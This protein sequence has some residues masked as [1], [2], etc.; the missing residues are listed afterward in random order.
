MPLI[1]FPAVPNVPG[2]PALAR[3]AVPSLGGLVNMAIAA[4]V[5]AVLGAAVWGVFDQS[6]KPALLPDSFLDID[7]KGDSRVANYPV[8]RGGFGSYNKVQFPYDCRLRMAIGAD[9]VTRTAFLAQCEAMKQSLD[10]FTVITPE[11]TFLN[12]TLQTYSYR[13]DSRN[14]VTLIV[15]DLWF[16][17]VREIIAAQS[18]QPKEA[19]GAD[20]VSDG[21]VQ[22]FPVDAPGAVAGQPLTATEG[23][24]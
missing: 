14:G 21:Q 11:A 4:A 8:E 16:A 7:A 17:E 22:A 1:P 13:R 15:V 5:Q 20:P 6:G 2:V 9:L 10:R 3:Q 12:A 24:L 19:G 18:P 23:I